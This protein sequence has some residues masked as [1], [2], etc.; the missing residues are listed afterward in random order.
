MLML[1]VYLLIALLFSFMCSIAEAVLL[2]V[3][4]GHVLLLQKNGHRCAPTLAQLQA[5][6]NKPLAA[7]LSLNTIAHTIGAAGVGAQASLVFGSA[8]LGL[9]S[10]ALT[11]LILV[12]SE[13]IPKSLGAYYWKPLAPATAYAL[14]LLVIVMYPLVSFPRR[15][16]G[17]SSKVRASADSAAGNSR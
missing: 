16:P 17:S 2:S 15:L 6:I 1:I 7:I 12:F 9:T 3:T 8:Y 5:D 10:A 4:K 13:I 14:R 11:L